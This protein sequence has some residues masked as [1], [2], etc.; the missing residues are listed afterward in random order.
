MG[1]VDMN[2]DV[3]EDDIDDNAIEFKLSASPL[4]CVHL[5]KLYNQGM[6]ECLAEKSARI[7]REL[8][9]TISSF[10]LFKKRTMNIFL[11]LENKTFTFSQ[12]IREMELLTEPILIT[13]LL[14]NGMIGLWSSLNLLLETETFL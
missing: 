4:F 11:C 7:R 8:H 1:L 2:V 5:K 14:V 12:S 13:I 6:V 3:E 10:F 9:P